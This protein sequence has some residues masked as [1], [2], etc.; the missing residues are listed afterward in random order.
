MELFAMPTMTASRHDKI[1]R[2]QRQ[3]GRKASSEDRSVHIIASLKTEGADAFESGR[4]SPHLSFVAILP[5]PLKMFHGLPVPLTQ[6]VDCLILARRLHLSIIKRGDN[7]RKWG[8]SCL[9]ASGVCFAD[10]R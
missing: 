8:A 6:A 4:P 5:G 1:C 7:D 9:A 3:L 10:R 2:Q